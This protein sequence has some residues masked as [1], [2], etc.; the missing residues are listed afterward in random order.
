MGAEGRANL[1]PGPDCP[2]WPSPWLKNQFQ[3]APGGAV[4]MEGRL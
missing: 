3:F 2:Q 4:M 1:G